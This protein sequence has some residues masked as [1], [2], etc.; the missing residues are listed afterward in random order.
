MATVALALNIT[1]IGKGFARGKEGGEGGI[2]FQ[3][4]KIARQIAGNRFFPNRLRE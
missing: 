2:L 4:F 1:G 3:L